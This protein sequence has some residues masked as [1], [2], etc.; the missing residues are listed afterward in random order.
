LPGTVVAGRYRIIALL[1][2][3]GM[4]EVYRADDLKLGQPVALKFLPEVVERDRSRLDRFLNEVRTALKVTHPNVCR[5]YDIGEIG[6]STP[7]TPSTSSGRASSGQASSGQAGSGLA[8]SGHG[9]HYISMEYVDGED[10]AS[11]LRRIGR[12]PRDKAAQIARQIC[13]GLAAA[14]DEGIVHRDLKPANVMIDGRGRAKITDFGLASL[15]GAIRG[16]EARAGTPLYMAPEQLAGREVTPRSDIYSLGLVLYELFTGKRAFEAA[17]AAEMLRLEQES[18]PTNPSSHVEGFDPA[19]E[20]AI[21]RCLEKEPG[22]RPGSALSVAASLPGGDPLAAALA[23]G[24]TPS[25]EMVAAAGPRGGLSPVTAVICLT[26]VILG[27]GAVMWGFP[28]TA[29]IQLLPF[30][31][32][33]EALKDDAREIAAE[34]GYAE[35]PAD[36]EAHFSLDVFEFLHLVRGRDP[37]EARAAVSR[38]GQSA[39]YFRYRQTP[40]SLVPNGLD[41]RIGSNNPPPAPGDLALRLDLGGNLVW[42]RVVPSRGDWS[43]GP[44]PAPDWPAVFEAAGLDI[45]AFETTAPTLR[46]TVYADTRMAWNGVLPDAGDRPVRIEAAALRG[47]PV[48]FEKV[49][50]SDPYWSP[51]SE[52]E[53]ERI[54]ST[55]QP[56]NVI[57]LSALALVAAGA[58]FLAIRNLR[59]GRGDPKGALRLALFVFAF[60]ML[61]RL[62]T[63]HHVAD[64]AE[65]NVL[66]V[67]LCGAVTFGLVIYVLY[68]ALEPYVRKLWPESVV[69][70]TRLLAGR[71]RDPLVGRD[72]LMGQAMIGALFLVTLPIAWILENLDLSPLIPFIPLDPLRGGRYAVGELFGSV[73][74]IFVFAFVLLMLF[75]LL[76][77]LL[78]RTWIAAAVFVVLWTC[79]DTLQLAAF[80]PS[81]YAVGILF[82]LINS[83]FML[84]LL[85]RFGLVAFLAGF[86]SLMP[87]NR[88]PTTADV[89]APYF[90]IGLIPVFVTL[91][92]AVYAFRTALAGQ[93]VFRDELLGVGA[94]A[95]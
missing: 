49:V 46:P 50:P 68:A 63:G 66:V 69:S 30:D 64:L 85:I 90:T 59:L 39:V 76:R 6:P 9:Q 21:L 88:F 81:L 72:V 17:T 37:A 91:A 61:S 65:L 40:D 83:I 12:L 67:A 19:V 58:V 13:A 15:A 82:G 51:D 54:A 70:W 42:M 44:D 41:G 18:A 28:A 24:E 78:R 27:L 1:G 56:I 34:L 89:S 29:F 80:D 45:A 36:S 33:F 95:R 10:L 53:R 93:A 52:G 35:S 11:L 3:G 77:I 43:A 62:V 60:Q 92:L 16:R 47:K 25:P 4:G 14:H 79:V 94:E 32:S 55:F 5:V 7:L 71:F 86:V 23:A 74:F 8:S 48:Y 31:K 20:R 73:L 38:R 75:L 26:L 22:D 57:V 84:T 2:S 87:L